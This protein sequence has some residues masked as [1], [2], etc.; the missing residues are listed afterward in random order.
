MNFDKQNINHTLDPKEIDELT[1]IEPIKD[2]GGNYNLIMF[3]I[4]LIIGIIYAYQNNNIYLLTC[5]LVFLC[6][7]ICSLTVGKY[8]LFFLLV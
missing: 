3:S 7:L 2:G 6:I 8:L 1:K 4:I 5:L